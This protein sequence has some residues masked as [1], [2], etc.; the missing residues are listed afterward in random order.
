ML[1]AL[2]IFAIIFA[3]PLVFLSSA[4]HACGPTSH[5]IVDGEPHYRIRM[6]E[7]HDSKT[8]IGAIIFAQ[9]YGATA[10]GTIWNKNLIKAANGLGVTLVAPKS[11]PLT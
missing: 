3:I 11:A 1:N 10:V 4:S 9:S 7:D 2:S 6:L 8:P 5:C